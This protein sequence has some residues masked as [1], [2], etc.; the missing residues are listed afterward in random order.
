MKSEAPQE[1]TMMTSSSDNSV[2]HHILSSS[3]CSSSSNGEVVDV[4]VTEPNAVA[5]FSLVSIY[6]IG[7]VTFSCAKT[8]K[9]MNPS[10]QWL[11]DVLY[12]MSMDGESLFYDSMAQCTS[13]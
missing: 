11:I 3:S 4:Q 12:L 13:V 1:Q 5:V 9:S 7:P 6:K 2:D 8:R 10:E